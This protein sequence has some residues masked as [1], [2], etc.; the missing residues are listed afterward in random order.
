MGGSSSREDTIPVLTSVYVFMLIPTT[1]LLIAALLTSLLITNYDSLLHEECDSQV[2]AFLFG[3]LVL[4]YA[5]CCYHFYVLFGFAW[6]NLVQKLVVLVGFLL[7]MA[8][9]IVNG[10]LN[11]QV[12]VSEQCVS[13]AT[14]RRTGSA[15]RV[16]SLHVGCRQLWLICVCFVVLLLASSAP[17]TIG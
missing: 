3:C 15:L 13:G 1:V 11:L 8:L 7:L 12:Q 10:H 4:F 5:W 14:T 2:R 9:W 17:S 6:K 16:P